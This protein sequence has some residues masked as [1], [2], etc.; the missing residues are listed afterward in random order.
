MT[1]AMGRSPSSRRRL[2]AGPPAV[3]RPSDGSSD[4]ANKR[5]QPLQPL[6]EGRLGIHG[7]LDLP[8]RELPHAAGRGGPE[9]DHQR[10]A[11]DPHGVGDRED[12]LDLLQRDGF[13]HGKASGAGSEIS[14]EPLAPPPAAPTPTP[15]AAARERE[16]SARPS[17]PLP[18]PDRPLP[19]RRFPRR[20]RRK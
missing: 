6:V 19:T 12:L 7:D 17:S 16:R 3:M 2:A 4:R 8:A 18:S 13:E 11:V 10:L 1:A 14:R 20:Q 9:G 5:R 15:P